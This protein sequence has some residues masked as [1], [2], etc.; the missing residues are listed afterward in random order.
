MF[1]LRKSITRC[2]DLNHLTINIA[3]VRALISK[4]VRVYEVSKA[5]V[6]YI[7]QQG[8]QSNVGIM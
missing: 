3:K 8:I 2:Q 7:I 1:R 6:G 5:S 4:P